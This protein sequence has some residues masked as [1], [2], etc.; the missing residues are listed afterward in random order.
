MNE[1]I[2]FIVILFQEIFNLIALGSRKKV[3]ILAGMSD[4]AFIPPPY[5][6]D[7]Y[8]QRSKFFLSCIQKLDFNTDLL[9]KIYRNKN[10]FF[11]DGF[12]KMVQHTS[13]F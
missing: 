2:L 4:K 10:F 13:I 9:K 5:L 1:W 6:T 8:E 3:I 11:L 7:I 12:L